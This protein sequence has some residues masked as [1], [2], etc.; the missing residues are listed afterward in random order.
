LGI[1]ERRSLAPRNPS[2]HVACCSRRGYGDGRCR[3]SAF[4]RVLLSEW[5]GSLCVGARSG[6]AGLCGGK[7][8]RIRIHTSRCGSCRRTIYRWSWLFAG[9]VQSVPDSLDF[10]LAAPADPASSGLRL[11][12]SAE[13]QDGEL[14]CK[15]CGNKEIVGLGVKPHGFRTGARCDGFHQAVAVV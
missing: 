2:V 1:S 7:H 15:V 11:T 13:D 10:T 4:S 12:L 8:T 6:L 14:P 5:G 3:C 9:P